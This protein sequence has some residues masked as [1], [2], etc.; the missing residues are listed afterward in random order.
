MLSDIRAMGEPLDGITAKDILEAGNTVGI[1]IGEGTVN[2]PVFQNGKFMPDVSLTFDK[3]YGAQVQQHP[4]W[5]AKHLSEAHCSYY[6]TPAVRNP[7][8]IQVQ[9]IICMD[10]IT[11]LDIGNG[12]VKGTGLMPSGFVSLALSLITGDSNETSILL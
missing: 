6:N 12:Y 11:G 9:E 2:Y 3:G 8:Y 10:F 5:H 1:D 4:P 7:Q